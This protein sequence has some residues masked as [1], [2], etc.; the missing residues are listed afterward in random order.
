M[1][2]KNLN[3]G[4]GFTAGVVLVTGTAGKTGTGS[5]STAGSLSFFRYWKY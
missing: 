3:A 5:G 4:E 2:L 1:V